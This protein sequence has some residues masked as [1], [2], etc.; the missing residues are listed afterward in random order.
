MGDEVAVLWVVWRGGALAAWMVAW[1]VDLW[2]S[3]GDDDKV[4]GMVIL[5][6][7]WMAGKWVGHWDQL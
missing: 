2:V 5:L 3:L 1:R 4:V 6:V 7:R